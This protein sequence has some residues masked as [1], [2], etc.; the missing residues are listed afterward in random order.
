MTP[1]SVLT[2]AIPTPRTDIHPPV[3]STAE[4]ER[5]A[6]LLL[7]AIGAPAMAVRPGRYDSWWEAALELLP[8]AL[9][10]AI[11]PYPEPGSARAR[12]LDIPTLTEL[13]IVTER[14]LLNLR[15]AIQ[16]FR[17]ATLGVPSPGPWLAERYQRL[18]EALNAAR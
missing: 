14:R 9:D 18:T 6:Y 16:A 17:E 3:I 2:G 8:L 15:L 10:A 11:Y 4:R 5:F 1:G 7:E 12:H 13:Q